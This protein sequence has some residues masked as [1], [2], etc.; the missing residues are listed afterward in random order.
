MN[1]RH[2][3]LNHGQLTLQSFWMGFNQY[4]VLFQEKSAVHLHIPLHVHT[5]VKSYSCTCFSGGARR[6]SKFQLLCMQT[7][8]IRPHSSSTDG[9]TKKKKKHIMNKRHTALNHG[10]LTLQ[11]F[12]MGFNQYDVLFQEKS[13][14]HLHIP[15]HVH[16][17]VKSFICTCFSGG[18]CRHSKFQLL[19]T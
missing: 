5:C 1:K 12:W 10:Q 14:V 17:C 9:K 2:T 18:A 15:L 16:T 6:H 8:H 11:S 4:D 7:M 13:A 19:C 3:A